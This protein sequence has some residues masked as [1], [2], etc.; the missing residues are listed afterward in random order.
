MPTDPVCGM[1]VPETTDLVTEVDGKKYYFCSSGCMQKFS[2]P[3]L[4]AKKL[5]KRLIL[6]WILAVPVLLITYL[7]S[8]KFQYRDYILLALTLPIQF[9]SGFGFYEGAWH[10]IK[11]KSA[12]MDLL[13]SIGT[14][15]AFIFSL[16]ITL[17]PSAIPG[18][19][20]YYDASAFI[21][22]LILTGNFIESIMKRKANRAAE[23]L[24][25]MMPSVAHLVNETGQVTDV[26]LDSIKPG[27]ILN[28]RAGEVFPADG[29]IDNGSTEVDE[30]MI[31]GE[32]I[33]VF[34]E[35]GQRI[36]SGTRNINGS[37]YLLV[38]R[39]GGDSTVRQIYDM[40]ERASSGRAKVQRIADVFS[41]YFVPVVMASAITSSLFWY[42]Y[43]SSTGYSDPIEVSV[44]AFVSVIVIACP[45]AIGLAGPITLLISSNVSSENGIIIKNSSALDR[46]SKV[47]RVVMDKTGTITESEPT[48]TGIDITGEE[49][50]S[51]ILT[52]ASSMEMNSNHP[53][54][55][56]IQSRAKLMGIN[57]E[58]A[59]D[60]REIPGTGIEG[61]VGGIPVKI[62]KSGNEE[63]S[64]VKVVV[65]GRDVAVIHVSYKIRPEA[66]RT[67]TELKTLG[68]EVSI[69]SGDTDKE[70]Q[71]IGEEIGVSD[72][73]SGIL[74]EQKAEIVK[75]FQSNGDYVM[76]VGDGINDSVA[77]ETSDVGVAMG[78]GSDIARESGDVILLNNNL[79]NIVKVKLI[80]NETI[81]KV[82]QNIGWAFGYNAIL[83]PVAAGVLVPFLGLSVYTILPIL[84]AFAMGMSSSSVVMN[85]L[86][87]RPRIRKTFRNY[88]IKEMAG[89]AVAME[90]VLPSI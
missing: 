51:E 43:L 82:R 10:S 63:R 50:E 28:V 83:I 45:C 71:A 40:I 58:K 76:F 80:G 65:D 56:A 85:S 37:I 5:R 19:G 46:L 24:M 6:S 12:N 61:T 38:K 31:T 15:T 72:I 3:D 87:L 4:E 52:Y 57:P 59:E 70:V 25:D 9:Y 66:K 34:R 21:I 22:T 54:A 89:N 13:V 1:F 27:Q 69:V 75:K 42:F 47:N 17:F 16:F 44:L 84:S 32:Q 78:S 18:A 79:E 81:T 60:I 53:I 73:Y 74:P 62:R 35:K 2:S 26:P 30:S 20:V 41:Y 39:A 23:R 68:I 77:L 14:L 29:V 8:E 36:L 55:R 67:I 64:S 88:S 11:S 48:V 49:T 33:P 7:V 86:L 90:G